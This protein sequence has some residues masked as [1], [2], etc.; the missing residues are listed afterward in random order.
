M[1]WATLFRQTTLTGA[2]REVATTLGSEDLPAVISLAVRDASEGELARLGEEPTPASTLSRE[3]L[4]IPGRTPWTLDVVWKETRPA[5]AALEEARGALTA[6]RAAREQLRRAERG[7]DRRTRELRLLQELA[8]SAAEARDVAGLFEKSAA[9]LCRASDVEAVAAVWI[10]GEK[11]EASVHLARPLRPSDAERLVGRA[12]AALGQSGPFVGAIET[13]F[14]EHYDDTHGK[15]SELREDECVVV[16]IRRRG[17][18]AGAVVLL[19]GTTNDTPRRLA[20]GAANQLSLHLDRI[21]TV[22]E[23]E[24][25]RFRAILDSMSQAVLLTDRRLKIMQANP[26]ASLLLARLGQG[27]PPERLSRVGDLDLVPLAESVA[28]DRTAPSGAFEARLEDGTILSV[29]LSVLLGERGRVEGLVIVLADVTE[30]HRMHEQLAHNEKLSSLGQMMSGVAHELNNPLASVIGYAQLARMTRVDDKLAKRL[31]VIDQEAQRCRKIVQNLLSFARR[32]EP[33]TGL[34]S[35]NDVVTSTLRLVGYQLRVD[36]IRVISTL[37]PDLAAVEGD[38][39][40]LQ[41]AILN[42]VTNAQHAIDA[43]GEGGTIT[44]TT[45]LVAEDRVALE[46]GD[47]GPGIPRENRNRIFDPFF[48]TKPAGLGTGLGLSLVHSIV[49]AHRGTIR[50][51]SAEGGGALFRIELPAGR[52]PRTATGKADPSPPRPPD[53]RGRVLVVDD[54]PAVARLIEEALAADGHEVRRTGDRED[55]LTLMAG[56]DFDVIVLDLKM[57]GM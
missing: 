37:E 43:A 54:E 8:R 9:V 42:L 12:A 25:G 16:P 27:G 2:L 32:H 44:V 41:Q 34:L 30:T 57:P 35:L 13:V 47:D 46:V 20:H 40:Q 11:P 21:L 50:V 19:G 7:L 14:L 4:S 55:A 31:E 28:A 1:D 3:E 18:P 23:A 51:G 17:R 10:V 26:A 45:R 36:N 52:A 39:H 15:R 5:A 6:W 29:T 53:R 24:R 49:S 33:E 48:T 38:P 22:R 56:H